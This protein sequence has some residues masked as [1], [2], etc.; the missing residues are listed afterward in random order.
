MVNSK[1]NN[2]FVIFLLL[3]V[4]AAAG[5]LALSKTTSHTVEHE[6]KQWLVENNLQDKLTWQD[7]AA[8]P[9]GTAKLRDVK[10]HDDEQRILFTAE[11][12]NLNHYK[13]TSDVFELDFTFKK[14]VDVRNQFFQQHLNEYFA[15][16]GLNAPQAIDLSWKISLDSKAQSASFNPMIELPELMRLGLELRTDS[17]EVYQQFVALLNDIKGFEEHGLFNIIPHAGSIRL[18]SLVLNIEDKGGMGQLQQSLKESTLL[19]E[20]TP[21]LDQQR[22]ELWQL[23]LAESRKDCGHD[24]SFALVIQNQ[25]LACESLINFMSGQ[26]ESIQLKITATHAISLENAM[27]AGMMGLSIERLLAQYEAVVVIE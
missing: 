20:S 8:S 6:L 24:Q 3:I 11:E 12:L 16:A 19:G 2:P 4:L 15:D 22:E 10:I 18:N 27:L 5:W 25:R 17:P 7:L 14:L 9:K 1:I 23:R 21:E 13:K 26:K